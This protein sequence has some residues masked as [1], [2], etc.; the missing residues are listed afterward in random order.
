MTIIS[1]SSPAW[2]NEDIINSF[3]EFNELYKSRPI[4]DNVGG[5]KLPH[6]FASFFML[7]QLQP[8]TIIESGV[9]KGQGTWLFERACPNAQIICL[10]INFN[11]L[12]YKSVNAKYIEKDFSLVNFDKVHKN[13]SICFFDDHQ[14]AL[15]RLQQMKWKGFSKAIF[16]DNYPA[17][18][19]DCYSL[20]KMFADSGFVL[21]KSFKFTFKAIIK[22]MLQGIARCSNNFEIEPNKTHSLELLKN[23][24]LYYE[25][26]PLFKEQN[27]RWGDK[28]EDDNYPTKPPL[29][30]NSAKHAL[31]HEALFYT[32]ICLVELS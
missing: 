12:V 1:I 2:T 24:S 6:A 16:E 25:F 20:K 15:T 14:S 27:T 8:K 7:K 26:P 5:M 28:W 30:D 13:T 11:N 22:K 10:D 29:F 32:W 3:D 23:L 9:W 4:K 19:G 18:R 31:H 17:K 21:E